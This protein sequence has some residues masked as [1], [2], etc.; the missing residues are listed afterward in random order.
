MATWIT[1]EEAKERGLTPKGAVSKKG[2]KPVYY[3]SPDSLDWHQGKVPK[4]RVI[5][6]VLEITCKRPVWVHGSENDKYDYLYDL[7]E[8]PHDP[9]DRDFLDEVNMFEVPPLSGELDERDFEANEIHTDVYQAIAAATPFIWR[10]RDDDAVRME[11]EPKLIISS[12]LYPIKELLNPIPDEDTSDIIFD[13]PE[14]Q[15]EYMELVAE[16][17]DLVTDYSFEDPV[18]PFT[19]E[20]PESWANPTSRNEL[21]EYISNIERFLGV[22]KGITLVA[23]RGEGAAW[24][25]LGKDWYPVSTYAYNESGIES[26]Q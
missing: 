4:R 1:A 25:W 11:P 21:I 16:D 22:P 12:K 24:V 20:G 8:V 23:H 13:T 18:D 3:Y 5:R 10:I 19:Y 15:Q 14:A 26:T 6:V 7:T 9:Y 2:R 17:E